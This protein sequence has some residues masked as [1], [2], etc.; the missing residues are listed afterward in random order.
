MKNISILFT[1]ALT[2]MASV[3]FGQSKQTLDYI[4]SISGK[5]TLAGQLPV[6]ILPSGAVIS[7]FSRIT[8]MSDGP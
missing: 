7:C 2:V 1:A 3:T 8:S 5:Y 6:N 4:Q